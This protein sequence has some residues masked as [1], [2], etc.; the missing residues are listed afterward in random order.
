MFPLQSEH[1]LLY[2]LQCYWCTLL[3]SREVNEPLFIIRLPAAIY[4]THMRLGHLYI[5]VSTADKKG[6]QY[7]RTRVMMPSAAKPPICKARSR[8]LPMVDYKY[9]TCDNFWLSMQEP[10][11][12]KLFLFLIIFYNIMAAVA[13]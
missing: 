6:I 8:I 9:S 12:T 3:Y 7:L 1:E 11:I 10:R 13:R 5:P 2:I 4:S